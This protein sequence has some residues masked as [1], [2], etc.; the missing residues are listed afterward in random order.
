MK[1]K[2]QPKENEQGS[3]ESASCGGEKVM[4]KDVLKKAVCLA[5]VF[6]MTAVM[7]P[8]LRAPTTA[9][10]AETGFPAVFDMRNVDTD[11]DGIGD[12]SWVTGIK[13]QNPFG[14]CWGFAAIAAAESS[15]LS[16]SLAAEG[17]Y[18]PYADPEN[19]IE[20]LNLSEKHLAYF[21]MKTVDDPEDPQ[22]GEGYL[23]LGEEGSSDIYNLGGT[24]VF[25]TSVFAAGTG[26]VHESLDEQLEY[27]GREGLTVVKEKEQKEFHIYSPDDDWNI[28]DDYRFLQSYVLKSSCIIPIPAGYSLEERRDFINEIKDVLISG[29]AVQIGFRADTSMPGQ[30]DEPAAFI[31]ENWAH[32]TYDED[33]PA[34]H[35]VTIIGWDDN[36][37]RENFAHKIEGGGDAPI[38]EHDGAW[39]VRN[40]WGSETVE[41]PNRFAW[42]LYTGQDHGVYNEETGKYEYNATEDAVHTGYFWLSYE[43]KS[44][45]AAESL[46]FDDITAEEGY[47]IAEHDYMPVMYFRGLA[48]PP[49]E[50]VSTANVFCIGDDVEAARLEMVT[51]E[52]IKGNTDVHVDVYLLDEDWENPTDGTLVSQADAWFKHGGYNKIRLDTPVVLLRDQYFSVVVTQ[53]GPDDE[54]GTLYYVN[55][56]YSYNRRYAE[57]Q[58]PSLMNCVVGIVNPRESFVGADT[59]WDDLSEIGSDLLG[60]CEGEYAPYYDFDNFPIK[61]FLAVPD[62]EEVP[63]EAAD[64]ADLDQTAYYYDAAGWLIAENRAAGTS[65]DSFSP[66]GGCSRAQAVT[67]LWHAAGMPEPESAESPFRDVQKGDYF[68]KAVLWAAENGIVNGVADDVF[69]PGAAATRAHVATMLYR[70]EKL[71]GGGFTDPWTFPDGYRD[72]A[73]V[74]AYAEEALGWLTEKGIFQGYGSKIRPNDVCTRAQAASVLYRYFADES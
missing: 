36:Y 14:T 57:E 30:E 44:I 71:K 1:D 13:L 25:A 18:G 62:D 32:Y 58:V 64:Y 16:S 41:F 49:E 48:S 28:D 29:H 34:N 72:A 55:V 54:Y 40:S 23:F 19:G 12:T 37:P 17:G 38:P 69:A 66:E 73:D 26:P 47:F 3:K 35:A 9:A 68:R 2:K 51:C 46:E 10:E 21:T 50:P 24:S 52:A 27:R 67:W 6:A 39:L 63:H 74:P 65:P 70:Y 7:F 61:A 53:T 11:G 45:D 56:Q 4:R 8:A 42:G 43:D 20:E 22:Y 33:I 5:V 15:I 31:S 59:V 60:A